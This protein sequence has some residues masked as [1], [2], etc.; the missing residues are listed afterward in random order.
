MQPDQNNSQGN[1]PASPPAV[2]GVPAS[3]NQA[4]T[5]TP[6]QP[7]QQA[8]QPPQ[9][10]SAVPQQVTPPPQTVQTGVSQQAPPPQVG[11]ADPNQQDLKSNA[12]SNPNST[13]NTMQISE[14]RDGLMIMADGSY[15]AAVFAKSVNFD[16]MSPAEREA[17]EAG[18]QGFL[19]SLYFPVQIYVHSQKI[20]M[21]PYLERL[22]GLKESQDNMLLSMLMEDYIYF[23]ED[24]V[25][26][27]NIMDKSFY[28]IVPY[29][30][31]LN[32]NRVKQGGKKFFGGVFGSSNQ[33][34][35]INSD[36]L[37]KAKDELGNRVQATMNGL[38]QMSV[39]SVP[40][41]TQELIEL[42]Y[43]A[44]NPDTAT[45]QSLAPIKDLEVPLVTKG[46]GEAKQPNLDGV[47]Y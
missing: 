32:V 8:Y 46:Q 9:P 26:R 30:P 15:R 45:R 6:T 29:D 42:F 24:L 41:D 33:T 31:P 13:Q 44:Y 25:S 3:D 20:D 18:Y 23:I 17:V 2:G 10:A 4:P 37:D 36:D 12:K 43:D 47:S 34:V 27:S 5:S 35:T 38:T 21:R 40:L 19:N 22:S 28:V 1:I 14:I 16:L 39:Q 7:V 11:S